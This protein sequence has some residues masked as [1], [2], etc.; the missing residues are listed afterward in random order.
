M[1]LETILSSILSLIVGGGL[2]ALLTM[3]STRKKADAEA[4]QEDIK[5][6]DQ[7]I[8]LV[9]ELQE[10]NT[11]L[12]R[13]I[14]DLRSENTTKGFYLCVHMGCPL[15]RPTLGRGRIYFDKHREEENLG[16]DYTPIE[17]LFADYKKNPQKYN[18]VII[19]KDETDDESN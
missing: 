9:K 13:K 5:A 3:R 11:E 18:P 10:Q 12:Q 14:A 1:A 6:I 2:T 7:S 15:R 4:S 16:G 19:E 17:T 8:E